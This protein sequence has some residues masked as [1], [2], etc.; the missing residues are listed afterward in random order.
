MVQVDNLYNGD[1]KHVRLYVLL[2]ILAVTTGASVYVNFGN[3]SAKKP[4]VR[5]TSHP[6]ASFTPELRKFRL[7]F[8]HLDRI[9]EGL[10]D[11]HTLSPE[12]KAFLIQMADGDQSG[13]AMTLMVG[14]VHEGLMPMSEA[15]SAIEDRAVKAS[16]LQASICAATYA[17]ALDLAWPGSDQVHHQVQALAT[18]RPDHSLTDPEEQ[19]MVEELIRRPNMGDRLHAGAVLIGKK[20]LNAQDTAWVEKLVNEQIAR[21]KGPEKAYWEFVQRV[22]RK[23][24]S[25]PADK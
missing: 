10:F 3:G 9:K 12:D 2:A 19:R 5:L 17:R 13:L 25:K 18:T 8:A 22:A 21:T 20:G 15:Q 7:N 1:V 23:K 14:A 6:R 24:N 16:G 4:P 11:N